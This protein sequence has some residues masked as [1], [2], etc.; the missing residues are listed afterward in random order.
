MLVPK[1]EAIFWPSKTEAAGFA[2]GVDFLTTLAIT[3]SITFCFLEEDLFC[4]LN[5]FSFKNAFKLLSGSIIF[6]V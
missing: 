1:T 4:S 5:A 2:F 3:S 6:V